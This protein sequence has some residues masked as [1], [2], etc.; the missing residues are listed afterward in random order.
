MLKQIALLAP[1]ALVVAAT[2]CVGESS[3]EDEQATPQANSADEALTSAGEG[4]ADEPVAS[5]ESDLRA[6]GVRAGGVRGG[7]VR[8]GGV[9]GGAVGAVGAVGVGGVRRGAV[10]VGGARWGGVR[11]GVVGVRRGWVNGVWAPGW[12]WNRGVW[13]VGGGLQYSCTTDVDCA[14][15][16]GPGVAVC[17][18]EPTVGLGQCV[19]PGW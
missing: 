1:F 3:S 5:S 17:S 10:G 8:V 6:G 12:G 11:G 18:F 4:V 9:R 16:L 13:V 15:Q 2:A 19:G 7:A 14:A